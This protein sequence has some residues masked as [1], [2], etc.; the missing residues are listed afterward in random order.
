MYYYFSSTLP[1][2]NIEGTLPFPI[3]EFAADCQRLLSVEDYR[4]ARL[5]LGLEEGTARNDALNRWQNFERALKNEI[6][7]S[8]AAARQQNPL[9]AV[10][11]E[12][13]FDAEISSTL[14]Q[15]V[16]AENP[17]EA[18]KMLL[19][20]QWHR[21]DEMALNQHFSFEYILTYAVKLKILERL[22]AFKTDEGSK[23]LEEILQGAQEHKSTG[24][25][26]NRSAGV[27][28]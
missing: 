25:Q 9:A 1:M 27:Q 12:R 13:E 20:L 26:E 24:A 16:K 11:G 10:R 17:L 21:L 2:L 18:E 3:E 15:A 4:D 22:N 28:E 19:R 8:R 6:A 7:W 5:A 14:A 23:K